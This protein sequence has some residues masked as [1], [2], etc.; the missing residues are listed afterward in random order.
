MKIIAEGV[1]TEE[2]F[3]QLENMGCEELQG[4]LFY[5]PLEVHQ[6]EDKWDKNIF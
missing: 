2:Q 5:K 3:D 4:Y 6:I 1:E